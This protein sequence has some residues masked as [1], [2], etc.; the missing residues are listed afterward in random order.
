MA[1]NTS[2]N[3]PYVVLTAVVI[4]SIAFLFAIL[5]PLMDSINETRA[6]SE[7]HTALVAE[8]ERFL[9]SLDFKIAQ[10]QSQGSVEQQLATMLPE[11]ERSQDILRVIDQYAKESGVTIT[12][13]TNNSSKATAQANAGKARGESSI[14]PEGIE[15]ITLQLNA[16]G[17]YQQMRAFFAGLEKSPRIIDVK[18]IVMNQVPGEIGNVNVSLILQL[19]ARAEE[20]I[21]L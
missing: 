7:S 12:T 4:V 2:L 1:I 15:T 19:Y 9:Q 10:L 21:S 6:S 14:V 16:K 17:A 13:L 5:Q 8:K 11:T 20:D 18:S 3:T